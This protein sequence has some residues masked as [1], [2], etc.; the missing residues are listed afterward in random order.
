MIAKE[1]IGGDFPSFFRVISCG[2]EDIGLTMSFVAQNEKR[3][4]L[5]AVRSTNEKILLYGVPVNVIVHFA[6][7]ILIGSHS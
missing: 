2:Q 1:A 5:L 3:F 7:Y 6:S 4:V